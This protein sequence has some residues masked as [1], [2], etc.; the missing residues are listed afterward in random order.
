MQNQS[1]KHK[2]VMF[3]LAEILQYNELAWKKKKG[4]KKVRI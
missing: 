1:H 2:R 3:Y 4:I